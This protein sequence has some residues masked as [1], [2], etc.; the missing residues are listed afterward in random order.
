MSQE[1]HARI[2]ALEAELL[3]EPWRDGRA[4]EG[5]AANG[6]SRATPKRG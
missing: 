6:S 2:A 4:G 1:L 3:G 5:G